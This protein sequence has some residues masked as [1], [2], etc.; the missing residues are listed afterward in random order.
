VLA[1]LS[2]VALLHPSQQ[3]AALACVPVLIMI[4][5]WLVRRRTL[6]WAAGPGPAEAPVL[7][8]SAAGS[9]AAGAPR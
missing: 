7:V 8:R 9:D 4:G 6:E 3:M 5:Y 2:L 1:V